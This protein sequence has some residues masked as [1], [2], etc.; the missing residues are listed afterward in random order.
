M[1]DEIVS[2]VTIAD[3]CLHLVLLSGGRPDYQF[4]YCEAM[5][6]YWD[7]QR[8]SF[9]CSTSIP[10][11]PIDRLLLHIV[12]VVDGFGLSLGFAPHPT[13]EGV[14]DEDSQKLE[15]QLRQLTSGCS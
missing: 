13:I 8:M 7:P 15:S 9:K 14:T 11:L 3:G 2:K 10:G 6:V 1:A 12:K 5:S 4:V